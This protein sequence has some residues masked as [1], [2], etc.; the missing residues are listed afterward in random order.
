PTTSLASVNGPSVTVTLPPASLTRAP[1]L[2]GNSPPHCTITQPSLASSCKNWPS[3]SIIDLDGGLDFPSVCFTIDKK[4]IAFL[5][6]ISISFTAV[7]FCGSRGRLSSLPD[8][9]LLEAVDRLAL[10]EV[11]EL[12]QL[13][14]FDLAVL[15]VDRRVGEAAGP[16]HGLFARLHL[17]DGVV[18]DWV[19]V[20]V[21]TWR[22]TSVL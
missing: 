17:D 11:L 15:S 8:A 14:D 12:E 13:A 4:R 21:G 7:V 10:A 1:A 22:S 2:V 6:R 3:A 9:H 5:L 16:F 20:V 18:C 19:L